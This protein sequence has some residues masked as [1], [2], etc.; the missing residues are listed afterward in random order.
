[1]KQN[2]FNCG[3][4]VI[5]GI[6]MLIV[7]FWVYAEPKMLVSLFGGGLIVCSVGALI[8]QML[9][10]KN[11]NYFHAGLRESTVMVLLFMGLS[12]ID[13]ALGWS[14][15]NFTSLVNPIVICYYLIQIYFWFHHQKA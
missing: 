13:Y 6:L 8:F 2:L 5:S 1:M 12:G 14:I 15:N 10:C 9:F 3:Y 4:F 7:N 11:T